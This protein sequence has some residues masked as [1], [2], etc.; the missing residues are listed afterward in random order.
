MLTFIRCF[1][2]DQ[3]CVRK[4]TRTTQDLVVHRMEGKASLGIQS[5]QHSCHSSSLPPRSLFYSFN[6]SFLFV[7]QASPLGRE[8]SLQLLQ[9]HYLAAS[10][11]KEKVSLS[12]SVFK[13]LKKNS[14]LLGT[15]AFLC[16]YHYGWG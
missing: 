5:T 11:R 13:L 3:L 8:H 4:P 6:L 2:H 15:H 7:F 1:I 16:T 10:Q 12:A 14:D 9:S